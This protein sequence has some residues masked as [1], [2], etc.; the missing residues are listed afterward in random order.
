[1]GVGLGLGLGVG[2]LGQVCINSSGCIR[3][4]V[5]MGRVTIGVVCLFG[6]LVDGQ[7]CVVY[8][9]F[10]ACIGI[11]IT[12]ITIITIG[13][14]VYM[15]H[16]VGYSRSSRFGIRFRIRFGLGVFKYIT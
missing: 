12:I 6:L 16:A 5:T 4:R 10:V 11:P 3:V 9:H 7:G 2:G 15:V 8:I 1:M 14:T 13:I